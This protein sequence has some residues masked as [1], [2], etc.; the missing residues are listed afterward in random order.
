[1]VC[2]FPPEQPMQLPMVPPSISESGALAQRT[3][4]LLVT[5]PD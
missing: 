1:M 5:A 4:G 2:P 3:D